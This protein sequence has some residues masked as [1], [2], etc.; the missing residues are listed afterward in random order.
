MRNAKCE[1]RTSWFVDAQPLEIGFDHSS[2]NADVVKPF[3]HTAL[4]M[5]SIHRCR[6]LM[7]EIVSGLRLSQIDVRLV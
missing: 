6:T 4:T 2:G 5:P 3:A 1:M 7:D